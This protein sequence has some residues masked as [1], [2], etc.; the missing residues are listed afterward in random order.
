MRLLLVPLLLLATAQPEFVRRGH[1]VMSTWVDLLLPADSAGAAD[2]VFTIFDE[3]GEQ[4]S[5]WK[6]SSPLSAVN[7]K[8][9]EPVRVPADLLALAQRGVELGAATDGAFDITWAA[10]WGVWDF[11]A[12][13]P[14]V[15]DSKLIEERRARVDYRKVV[16]DASAG[17][18]AIAPGQTVGLGGIAKGW[19][20]DK[21]AGELRARGI[22]DFLLTAGGQVVAGGSKGG[23]PWRV[24]IRDPRGA[25]DDFFAIVSVKDLSVSTS[26]DYERCFVAD[27]LL[28]HHIL[29]P[30]TGRPARGLRSVTV[31]SPDATVADALSTALFVMGPERAK[32]LVTSR[33]DVEAV[34]V[35]D[36]GSWWKS[37]GLSGFQLAHEPKPE[38]ALPDGACRSP[39]DP[40]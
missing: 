8:A 27:G 12:K 19:T 5:E 15:P 11:R 4:L 38:G 17:T 30:R 26:G 32:A 40:N 6:D 20:L 29:D 39:Q 2:A 34:L 1:P 13:T 24:G 31:V 35:L 21:A 16:V 7:R 33:S 9:G 37:P 10:L 36:D 22:S 18:L 23:A 3:A 25:A 28:Y 14:A